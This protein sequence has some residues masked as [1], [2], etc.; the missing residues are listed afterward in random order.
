LRHART[1]DTVEA[2]RFFSTSAMIAADGAGG[3]VASPEGWASQYQRRLP[4][5]DYVEGQLAPVGTSLQPDERHIARTADSLTHLASAFSGGQG[6][7]LSVRLCSFRLDPMLSPNLF[8]FHVYEFGSDGQPRDPFEPGATLLYAVVLNH[9]IELQQE[10]AAL[11]LMQTVYRQHRQRELR[12]SKMGTAQ[13]DI[14]MA[15]EDQRALEDLREARNPLD[16]SWGSLARQLHVRAA[17]AQIRLEVQYEADVFPEREQIV[18]RIAWLRRIYDEND[19]VRASVDKL[20]SVVGAQEPAVRSR[21]GPSITRDRLQ[22]LG[23]AMHFKY[24]L[25]QCLRDA[26]VTGNGY[27]AF[28]RT[29][30][31]GLYNLRPEEV[32]LLPDGTFQVHGEHPST[33]HG[34]HDVMHLRGIQQV[35][36]LYGISLLEAFMPSIVLLDKWDRIEATAASLAGDER[37]PKELREE[38]T[39]HLELVARSRGPLL[40]R[41]PKMLWF[42]EQFLRR[43]P[44]ICT[45]RAKSGCQRDETLRQSNRDSCDSSPCP[46]V[47]I[48]PKATHISSPTC[49]SGQTAVAWNSAGACGAQSG[50]Q[51]TDSTCHVVPGR[52]QRSCIGPGTRNTAVG[53]PGNSR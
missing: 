13:I 24:Y 11:F 3:S 4:S 47:A 25:N 2:Y 32:Q 23:G 20:V 40:D 26:E 35:H 45:F 27:V 8:G 14:E 9:S 19:A 34:R 39:R 30:P 17:D 51:R 49:A 43:R 48:G 42:P 15:T 38:A 36:S 37:A 53:G 46:Q 44:P 22:Q 29:E 7:V 52:R 31:V 18:N 6:D 5:E 33:L 12:A 50:E 21:G 16:Y 1:A 41:I 10:I 28:H